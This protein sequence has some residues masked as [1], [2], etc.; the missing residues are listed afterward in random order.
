MPHHLSVIYFGFIWV[1]GYGP[2]DVNKLFSEIPV[3][4]WCCVSIILVIQ[5][6]LLCVCLFF[7]SGLCPLNTL[8]WFPLKSWLPWLLSQYHV[9]L[10]KLILYRWDHRRFWHGY[11]CIYNVIIVSGLTWKRR[12]STSQHQNCL[13]L[14]LF[15]NIYIKTIYFKKS[16]FLSIDNVRLR[17]ASQL[18][19]DGLATNHCLRVNYSNLDNP[20]FNEIPENLKKNQ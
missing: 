14:A 17:S 15:P 19:L 18:K 12:K 11:I 16:Y 8:F 2:T 7:L 4:F 6:S 3:Y 20:V 13:W 5:F 10:W 9:G 1:A